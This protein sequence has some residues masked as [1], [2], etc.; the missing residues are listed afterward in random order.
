[1]RFEY[2]VCVDCCTHCT[3]FYLPLTIFFRLVGLGTDFKGSKTFC[4]TSVLYPSDDFLRR[5][6]GVT[7]VPVA[8]S[9]A[10]IE[11][12]RPLVPT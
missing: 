8:L 5:E 9:L 3:A 7:V 2:R 4:S 1:M 11:P 12:I 10:E 6:D